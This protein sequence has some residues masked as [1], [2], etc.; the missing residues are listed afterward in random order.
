MVMSG[1]SENAMPISLPARFAGWVAGLACARPRLMLWLVLS[2]ACAAVGYTVTSLKITTSHSG[3][4]PT[5]S[6]FAKN[7][8][9]YSDAFGADSDVLVVIETSAPNRNLIRS[10]IDDVGVRLTREPQHFRN[11]LA[12][13]DL[14][15]M[16]RKALQF[17]TQR[18]VQRT[19]SLLKTYDRVVREQN[20]ELIRAERIAGTL[21][22]QIERARENGVVPETTWTSAERFSSSLSSYLRNAKQTG[23]PERNAF[24]SPLPDLMSVAGDQ[25]LTDESDS[26]VLNSEGTVGVVQA[27]LTG[28]DPS[29]SML[30]LRQILDEV[31]AAAGSENPGLRLSVTGLPALEFDELR[32]SSIDMK[33]AGLLAVFTVGTLLLLVFRGLRYPMLVLTTL[34][35]SLC[36]TFGAATFIVG[37]LNLVSICFT[38]FLIGLSVD[39]SVS[40]IH[41][42]LALRQELLEIPDAI[43]NAARTTGGSIITSAITASLAFST[44]L[45]TGF[46]GLAEL[47]LI[48]AVGSILS[49]VAVFVFLPALISISDSE[50]DIEALPTPFSPPLLRKYLVAWPAPTAAAGVS[51]VLL[52][53]FQAFRYSDG[54]IRSRVEYNPSLIQL[55]D[56]AAESVRAEQRLAGSGTDTVL[57]AVAL[58]DSWEQAIQL[59][60]KFLKLASVAR[61]SDAASK[62]P[63]QPDAQ[64]VQLLQSLQ[65]Q[66]ASIN[67]NSPSL[68]PADHMAVGRETD[69]LYS[70]LKKSNHPTAQRAAGH[71]DQFLNDLSGTSGRQA[72]AILGAW[73]AMV[74]RWLL[75]EYSEIAAAD[76]FD[77]VYLNDLP[78]ELKSRYL[79]IRPD[80]TQQWALRIYPRANVWEGEALQTF[81]SELRTVDSSVTGLPIQMLESAGRMNHLWSSIGLYSIAV[82]SIVLLFRNLRPGQKLLTIAPPIAVAAFIGYTLQQRNGTLNLPLLVAIAMALVVL[83]SAVLDYR[84]LRDTLL[85]IVPALGGGLVLLGIMASTGVELNPLNLIALPLVFAIGIDNGIYLVS[86]CRRQIAERREHYEMSPETFSS[87]IVTSLT[88]IAGFGSLLIASHRGVFSMGLLLAL[89][90]A[91]CLAVAVLLMPSLLTLVARH[92][93]ASMDPVRMIRGDQSADAE[94][95]S[96]QAPRD[97]QKQAAGKSKK[98]A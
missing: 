20:W 69:R 75:M 88:S 96:A 65:Q 68:Q 48:S 74:A 21:G 80:K 94:E 9:Q 54:Q 70:L 17:L 56:P 27:G 40:L 6:L 76:R 78:Q 79:R 49:A 26:C 85:M 58:A 86:D 25:R 60:E 29:D 19:A 12:S 5:E 53:A 92:Q 22:D 81:V 95:P 15:T 16:R 55:Q 93:P 83:I 90:V 57:H 13:V 66:A 10:L 34:L 39:F 43:Q 7:W 71:L 89:G 82:I 52:F 98:A 64:T 46:P 8:A 24:Q 33:N 62:L 35:I 72:R 32:S 4:T 67:P 31:R 44:T 30:R 77:P 45:L 47:G 1:P 61:V 3:L 11:V 97:A 91:S 41:R 63:E 36:W 59:R 84:N 2:L 38:V 73:N 42:Y 37:H 51:L 14:S 28:N 87:V 50:V 23:S 18:E